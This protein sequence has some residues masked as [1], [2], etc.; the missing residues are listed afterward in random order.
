MF[1]NRVVVR[2]EAET[3]TAREDASL[4]QAIDAT[5]IYLDKVG[6]VKKKLVYGLGSMR[7]LSLRSHLS[8]S[9]INIPSASKPVQDSQTQAQWDG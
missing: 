1:Q 6:E 9:F 7:S 4:S 8:T 5:Q 2:Y 3:A